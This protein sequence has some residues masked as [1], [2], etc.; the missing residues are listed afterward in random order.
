MIHRTHDPDRRRHPV[1]THDDVVVGGTCDRLVERWQKYR[2]EFESFRLVDC[3]DTDLALPWQGH[4]VTFDEIEELMDLRLAEGIE[5]VRLLNQL[6]HALLI[7]YRAF[8]RDP[9]DEPAHQSTKSECCQSL[10]KI[11]REPIRIPPQR[12][13]PQSDHRRMLEMEMG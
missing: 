12:L 3:H 8:L 13:V 7:P 10:T 2:I 4:A 9:V 1:G 5:P 6:L 11:C